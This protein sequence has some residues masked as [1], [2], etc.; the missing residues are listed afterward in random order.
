MKLIKATTV[1]ACVFVKIGVLSRKILMVGFRRSR[2]KKSFNFWFLL[3]YNT[4]HQAIF[5]IFIKN[6]SAQT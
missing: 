3:P 4:P 2:S 1:L 6:D 5:A